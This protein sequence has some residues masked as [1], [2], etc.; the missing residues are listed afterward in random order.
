MVVS[1]KEGPFADKINK[2]T[3]K[4][5]DVWGERCDCCVEKQ[6]NKKRKVV[7]SVTEE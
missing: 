2:L 1:L 7:S 3:K 5:N 4:M 6:M